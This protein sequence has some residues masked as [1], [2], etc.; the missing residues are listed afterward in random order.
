MLPEFS[1]DAVILFMLIFVRV[2]ALIG[3]MPVTGTS[4]APTVVKA[5]AAFFVS[6]LADMALSKTPQ[7]VPHGL[8]PIALACAG[9]VFIGL[10]MGFTA[11]AVLE[12]VNFAGNI[13]GFQMGFT[14]ANVI[15]PITGAQVSI[16]SNLYSLVAAVLFIVSGLYR[17]FITG[18]ITS[19]SIVGPGMVTL[20]IGGLREFMTIGSEI[21]AQAVIIGAPWI[22][23]LIL[24]NIGMGLMARTFP[25]MNVFF[26]GF[27]VTIG[28]GMMVMAFA[29]PFIFATIMTFL[30]GSE[31]H[32]WAL[33][34]SVM[35]G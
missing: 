31:K 13:A 28:V 24:V 12:A 34:R 18:I 15:D 1:S 33:L 3:M 8:A 22:V 26:V 35:P 27:P 14:I 32:F 2:L 7:Q 16:I 19:F 30:E 11:V 21:F 6:L 25:Q 9:E 20:R 23:A 5:G 10:A 29:T 17:Q 4:D